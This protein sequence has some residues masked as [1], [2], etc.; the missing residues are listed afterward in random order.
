M[1]ELSDK[2]N[3]DLVVVYQHGDFALDPEVQEFYDGLSLACDLHCS[4]W[5]GPQAE[6][7]FKEG[8]EPLYGKISHEVLDAG[9][10][11]AKQSGRDLFTLD[12]F[13]SRHILSI[14]SIDRIMVYSWPNGP[15]GG[16]SEEVG[17][18]APEATAIGTP[19]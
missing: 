18:Q 11:D 12:T 1:T 14:G 19:D 15:M 6:V 16:R 3:G 13:G 10:L 7:F 5:A 8:G 17:Y 4:G 9:M 2:L